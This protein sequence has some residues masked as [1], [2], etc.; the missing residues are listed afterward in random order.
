MRLAIL[1]LVA[2][3]A[4]FARAAESPPGEAQA[5]INAA[6]AKVFDPTRLHE[7]EI[8][9][10]PADAAVFTQKVDQRFKATFRFDGVELKDVGV[11]QAGGWAHPYV[12]I[13]GKPSVSVKFNDFVKGQ[14]LFGLEK[15]ILKNALQDNSFVNEH[16]TYEVFRRAGL[17]APLTAHARVRFNGTDLGLYIIREAVNKQFLTRNFGKEGSTG[18]LYEIGANRIM[19]PAVDPA[20]IDLKDEKEDGRKRDDLLRY[21]AVLTAPVPA[22]FL[23]T[24]IASAVDLDKYLTFWAVQGVTSDMDGFTFHNNND[25]MYA[26][27]KDGRFVFIPHG[28]DET[29][30]AGVSSVTFLQSPL[31]PPFSLLPRKLLTVPGFPEQLRAEVVRVSSAPV[32]DKAAL[33]ARYDQVEKILA[34]APKSPRLDG[35]IARFNRYRKTIDD[36]ID[37][38]GTA[39]ALR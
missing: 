21:A 1:A 39:R 10:A 31:Q 4:G 19:D 23:K 24:A 16:M 26:L 6:V 20:S 17:P 14:D 29:F 13:A 25:Y 11:R 33:H 30:W 5:K 28:A 7:I 32:W 27:P 15:L 12:P 2:F 22:Q 3:I 38:G 18:N 8:V 37:G 36:F 35:D 9:I 34:A